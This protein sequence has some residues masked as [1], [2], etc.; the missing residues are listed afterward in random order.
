MPPQSIVIEY[1]GPLCLD[2]QEGG[3]VMS[4]VVLGD[5]DANMDD[6]LD[7]R[8]LRA[9]GIPRSRGTAPLDGLVGQ[10]CLRIEIELS[11][12]VKA[13]QGSG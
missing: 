13:L 11:D 3:F 5:M 8:I 1:K 10:C 7:V 4:A 6:G 9:C 12:K 2:V